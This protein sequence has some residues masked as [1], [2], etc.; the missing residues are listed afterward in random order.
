[1]S[2]TVDACLLLV[3]GVP[4][5]SP[6]DQVRRASGFDGL[7]LLKSPFHGKLASK[8][9]LASRPHD[10]RGSIQVSAAEVIRVSKSLWSGDQIA[11]H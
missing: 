8:A 11:P 4:V 7:N 3:I 5:K 9:N 10:I 1:V 2:C 6:F